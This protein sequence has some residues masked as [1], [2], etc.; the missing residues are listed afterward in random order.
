MSTSTALRTRAANH[1][2]A[3]KRALDF[4]FADFMVLLWPELHAQTDWTHPPVFLDK[5]LQRLAVYK[6]GK[7]RRGGR[8]LV[9]KLARVRLRSGRD[10]LALIHVE[11]QGPKL[12]GF[13]A[14]MFH[15]HLALREKHPLLPV[16]SL[17]VLTHRAQGPTTESY[18]YEHWGC[19]LT[20]TFP[21]VNLE[22]WRGRSGELARLA[23]SNPFAVVVLAQLEANTRHPGQERLVRK[24]QLIRRLIDWRYNERQIQALFLIIDAM[25]TLPEPLEQA[26]TD[27]VNQLEEETHMTYVTSVE[28]VRLQRERD[29]ARQEGLQ[30][31]LQK[32]Q[33]AGQ[34]KGAGELLAAQLTRK[35]GTLP[36]W[37]GVRLKQADEAALSRWAVQIL[38]AQR[39]EDVFAEN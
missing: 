28:R 20:F 8:L 9:D 14:R 4:Y 29:K 15:Y 3:W 31:G 23:P 27:I 26:F 37:A 21:V 22:S 17:A 12:T 7:T 39:I 30:K 35:F 32:G 5:E 13:A 10:M 24:T 18:A 2:G 34:L 19:S 25:L 38:D 16:A 36:D 1:D 33:Q 6:E 11:I